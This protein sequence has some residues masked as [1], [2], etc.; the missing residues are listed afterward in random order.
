MARLLIR[1]S[2]TCIAP[3]G[4]AIRSPAGNAG[5]C[6]GDGQRLQIGDVASRAPLE[7]GEV[8]NLARIHSVQPR[9]NL[10]FRAFERDLLPLCEEE[11]FA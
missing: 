6:T 5:Q 4:V 9:Y 10:L 2:S 8:K 1:N 11:G 7:R 3:S